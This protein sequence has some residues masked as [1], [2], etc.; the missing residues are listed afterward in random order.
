MVVGSN[1]PEI[2]SSYVINLNIPLPPL[3]EQ[4]KIAEILSIADDKIDSLKEKKD[5]YQVLKK[6]LMQQL[7]MGKMRVVCVTRVFNGSNNQQHGCGMLIGQSCKVEMR[8]PAF[9]IIY[10][11]LLCLLC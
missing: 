2:N 4:Q 8:G 7:L 6:G 11:A 1:Y 3:P 9:L 5:E 10:P